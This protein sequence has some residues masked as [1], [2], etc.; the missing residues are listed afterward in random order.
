MLK[1][2]GLLLQGKQ[3]PRSFHRTLKFHADIINSISDISDYSKVVN[4]LQTL[5]LLIIV[6]YVTTTKAMNDQDDILSTLNDIS[7]DHY[8][9]LFEL[10]SLQDATKKFCYSEVIGEP[11]RLK[12]NF[13]FPLEN[14]SE[15]IVLGQ[16]SLQLQLT[17]LQLLARICKKDKNA[18][19]QI[20]NRIL[21]L[22]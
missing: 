21:L 9:P 13:T 18:L 2:V 5:I 12:L 3:T 16:K 20:F 14:V 1:F 10:T 11:L 19:L 6:G 8:V 4:K 15:L 22:K 7:K 17:S